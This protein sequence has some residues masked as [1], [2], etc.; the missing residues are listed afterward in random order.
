MKRLDKKKESQKGSYTVEATLVFTFIILV[1]F[2]FIFGIMVLYQHVFLQKAVN[3]AVLVATEVQGTG[4]HSEN[5][6]DDIHALI[7]ERVDIEL[8][9]S[10]FTVDDVDKMVDIV[11]GK[12]GTFGTTDTLKVTINQEIHIPLGQ[13]KQFF[14][15]KDTVTI[16][17]SATTVSDNTVQTI[18]NTDLAYELIVRAFQ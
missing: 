16:S 12:L 10:I 5:V 18:R 17:A 13:I 11:T 7:R 14:S 2:A 6:Q 1:V 15:G 8:Q 9:K 3:S 4:G